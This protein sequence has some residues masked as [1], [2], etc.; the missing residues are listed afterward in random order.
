MWFAQQ[1][2]CLMDYC[3][4]VFHAYWTEGRDISDL[5]E[6]ATIAASVGLD[7]AAL[8][9]YVVSPEGIMLLPSLT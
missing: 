1:R 6:L 3:S 4:A 8:R 2:D 9:K 5:N 7:D